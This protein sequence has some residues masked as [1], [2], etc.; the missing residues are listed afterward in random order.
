M[1][2]SGWRT[3]PVLRNLA[4]YATS[5]QQRQQHH[6]VGSRVNGV[7]QICLHI[8][9]RTA[10]KSPLFAVERES[11]LAFDDLD[12]GRRRRRCVARVPDRPKSQTARPSPSHPGGWCA[13]GSVLRDLD[14]FPQI[15][16]RARSSAWL[17]PQVNR[18]APT[19]IL[20]QRLLT[21]V[22]GSL[23]FSLGGDDLRDA[24]GRQDT[25]RVDAAPFST[26]AGRIR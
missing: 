25:G 10:R 8:H 7:R 1:T 26:P 11:H 12:D 16:K 15:F 6:G 17:A 21:V 9:P 3:A 18:V 19:M 20:P 23:V 14:L 22:R 13:Q 2:F 24:A 4:S 5:E